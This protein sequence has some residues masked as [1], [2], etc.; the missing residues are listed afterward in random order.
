MHR[1]TAIELGLGLVLAPHV[2]GA[3]TDTK[4][5]RPREGDLLVAVESATPEPLKPDDVPSRGK[6]AMAWPSIRPTIR[7][8]TGRGST[9]FCCF[10]SILRAST[11]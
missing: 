3:Q 7:C 6:L 5:E 11:R 1:R 4:R 2:V 8:A 9:R 10:A